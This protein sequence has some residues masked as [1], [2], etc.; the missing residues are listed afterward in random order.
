MTAERFVQFQGMR[1]YKTGDYAKWT[2]SGE[3][4]ILG[5]TDNQVKLR[6]L[7]IELEEVEQ[8]ILRCPGIRQTVVLIRGIEGT[9]HLCAYYT[10]EE[11]VLPET[12]REQLK[13]L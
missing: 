11:A 7:R 8:A 4:V 9:E 13:T 5:R 2:R 12:L 1:V 10:A 3:V 6:G